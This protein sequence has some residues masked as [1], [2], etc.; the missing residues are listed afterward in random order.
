MT[1]KIVFVI[2]SLKVGGMERVMSEIL[3]YGV[4]STNFEIHL[5]LYGLKRDIFYQLDNRVI[6]H[7]PDFE[8]N[9][10]YRF[11]YTIKTL[12]YLRR[13]LI[14][15]KAHAIL[16]FGEFWNNLVLISLLGKKENI[17]ISDRC[18]PNKS[19]GFV[20][21]FLRKI[22]YPTAS[23][24][25]CQ[26]EL[27]SSVY[28]KN[29]GFKKLHVIGNPIRTIEL[30]KRDR[31]KNVVLTVGRFI[32]SKNID[33]LIKLFTEVNPSNWEFHIVGD[34]DVKQQ[35]KSN[36]FNL[37]SQYG[38][39]DK[40]K[41]FGFNHNIDEFYST[42]RIFIFASESE[43]FPNVVGEALSAGIPTIL[44]DSIPGVFEL[45][46][47]KYHH[48]IVPTGDYKQFKMKLIELMELMESH[49]FQDS[50]L[51]SNHILEHFGNEII[52][53]K[54]FNLLSN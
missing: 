28:S 18:N 39:E 52:C 19:L 45:V 13:I 17:F 24:I 14:K 49:E 46:P 43:G 29:L 7:R 35:N 23:G 6:I 47:E 3:N 36:Y 11:Y 34:D 2:P 16:S 22:L 41:L 4:Q 53:Q 30:E 48:L 51:L 44:F 25:I 9:N 33:K 27:A 8:F 21:D 5:V 12:L 40:I 20:H 26:T 32:K 38:I 31:S 50:L 10:N 15:F 42:S 37:I 1:V 54:Y